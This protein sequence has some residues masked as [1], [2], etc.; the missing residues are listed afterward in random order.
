MATKFRTQYNYEDL[1]K[2]DEGKQTFDQKVTFR[3]KG[4][5]IVIRDY[6][7]ENAVGTTFYENLEIYGNIPSTTEAMAVYREELIGDFTQA[8]S[9]I[10][11]EERRNKLKT[12]WEN[13]PA[14]IR[15][16]RFANKFQNFMNDGNKFVEE[17]TILFNQEQE[18]Y[19]RQTEIHNTIE[20]TK[21]SEAQT[22]TPE[23]KA[24]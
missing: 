12:I 6:V 1:R 8:T 16:K 13:L 7:Q 24:E 3:M 10:D 5:D 21:N 11:L 17:Q 18:A 20:N 19:A 22:T 14:E 2:K 15:S 4:K 9:L 23:P